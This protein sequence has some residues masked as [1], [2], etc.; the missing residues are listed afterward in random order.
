MLEKYAK[1]ARYTGDKDIMHYGF[2]GN[3]FTP[4]DINLGGKGAAGG[5]SA[6]YYIC[7]VGNASI[8]CR[9]DL[10]VYFYDSNQKSED[11]SEY[12]VAGETISILIP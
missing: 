5:D 6:D 2:M 10:A 3:Y 1:Y 11:M 8:Q 4:H 9:F 12:A 7:V